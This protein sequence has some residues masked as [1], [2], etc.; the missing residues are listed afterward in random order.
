MKLPDITL[1]VISQRLLHICG[2]HLN[3]ELKKINKTETDRNK[4]RTN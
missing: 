1:S 4:Q 2:F 3:V